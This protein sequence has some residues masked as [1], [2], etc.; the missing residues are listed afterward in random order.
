MIYQSIAE[1][2]EVN[3]EIRAK[4]KKLVGNLTDEQLHFLPADESWTV[5]QIVEH[6]SIVEDGIIKISAKLL[7]KAQENGGKSDGSAK[8][9]AEFLQK[10]FE[11]KNKK[12]AAPERVFPT[13]NLTIAESF[14]KMDENRQ[15]LKELRTLF[16]SVEETQMKFPHPAFGDMTSHEWLLLLG[17][18]EQRHIAQIQ[19]ILSQMH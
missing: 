9:S 14:E 4:L 18:H 13:G 8:I 6:I 15:K 17:G 5:K 12:F 11:G 16:E 7:S 19:R 2:Y 3:D 10:I 1:I